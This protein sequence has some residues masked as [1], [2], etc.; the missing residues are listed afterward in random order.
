MGITM[1][2]IA[3]ILGNHPISVANSYLLLK[4]AKFIFAILAMICCGGVFASLARG[5]IHSE[6]NH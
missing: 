1:L 4:S 5:K 6:N 2:I 3:V